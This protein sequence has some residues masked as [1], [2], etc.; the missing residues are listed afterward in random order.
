MRAQRRGYPRANRR[1]HYRIPKY[2]GSPEP[3]SDTIQP[4]RREA[5]PELGKKLTAS[6]HKLYTVSEAV[7]LD[8]VLLVMLAG[9]V[10]YGFRNGLSSTV[11]TLAGIVLGLIAV[12]FLVPLVS[13]LLPIPQL[14]LAVSIVLAIGLVSAGNGLGA[15]VGRRIRKGLAKSPLLGIDRIF[16]AVITGAVAALVA[17]VVCASVAQLGVPVLSRAI[18]GSGVLRAINTLTPNPVE[19]WL[20]QARG[21]LSDRGIPLIT[22]AFSGGPPV[23]PPIDA[24][25]PALTTAAK[26]V[27]RITG[28]AY[29]CGQ[30]QSGSGFVVATDRVMTNAHVVAGLTQPVV[31]A[32]NGQA[33]ASSIVYF[34]PS[35]DLAV[36]AVPGLDVATLT[37]TSP[38][39][40]G[41]T[42]AIEGYP[43]GG[44]FSASGASVASVGMS[45]VDDIY[46]KAPS[47]REVYTLGADVREGDSG[48][49]VL[50]RDGAV[51]GIVF[52]RDSK[53]AKVG[54]AMTTTEFQPL[55]T[56]AVGM[57]NAVDTGACIAG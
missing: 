35:H 5:A 41:A 36:L 13:R 24:G 23:V 38:L 37:L 30:S 3:A 33:I 55:A 20:A 8:V 16:G 11:F 39:P 26:S 48:G 7:V 46:G 56:Q 29:A 43:Y 57:T 22:Q 28:N 15:A 51:A 12:L 17:T 40:A 14:R 50:T 18:A 32:S 10:I 31:E 34:D 21:V 25:S 2:V 27:V 4:Q 44:P 19:A 47:D 1:L 52:A 53:T 9:Y 54:Y 6:A 42:A 49:P 45:T